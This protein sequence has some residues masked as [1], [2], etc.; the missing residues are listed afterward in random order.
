[1]GTPPPLPPTRMLSASHDDTESE[2]VNK[3]ELTAAVVCCCC[4]RRCRCLSSLAP[5]SA[6]SSKNQSPIHAACL[7][8]LVAVRTVYDKT[9]QQHQRP[10]AS[11]GVLRL[12]PLRFYASAHFFPST[13][14]YADLPRTSP[15]VIQQTGLI[16]SRSRRRIQTTH[17]RATYFT[18]YFP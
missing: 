16:H 4:C 3:I 18:K 8:G 11:G 2:K 15:R 10:H 1:M 7:L 17:T 9:Q 13:Q 12:Q 6:L 14:L 5:C